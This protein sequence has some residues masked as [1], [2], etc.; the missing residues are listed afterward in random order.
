MEAFRG[1]YR[2]FYWSGVLTS[3]QL[4]SLATLAAGFILLW[5]LPAA[6]P[7]TK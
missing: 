5:K 6:K 3:A 4:V 7:K 2:A 1:D